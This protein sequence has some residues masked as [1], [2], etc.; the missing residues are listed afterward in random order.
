MQTSLRAL[1]F[2][3]SVWTLIGYGTSQVL[4]LAGNLILTRLLFPEAFGLMVLVN[5]TLQGLNM[6]SDLGLASSIVQ[7]QRGSERI[8]LDTAWTIQV[9][10]GLFLCVVCWIL[11]APLSAFYG[12]PPLSEL[13]PVAG[14]TLALSGF[15]ST[16][17]STLVRD[18]EL[19]KLTA[20]DLTVQAGSLAAMVAWSWWVPTVWALVAGNLIAATLR[21]VLSHTLIPGPRNRP[22]FDR[23]SAVELGHFAR[24]IVLSTL[25]T[26]IAGYSD[27]IVL[28]RVLSMAELGVYN[29]AAVLAL[30]VADA[31]QH[32]ANRVLLPTYARLAEPGS[33]ELSR[34]VTRF[35]VPLLAG[36]L[37]P[38]CVLIAWA[39]EVVSFLYDD[40][41]H[42]AGWML[43]VLAVGTLFSCITVSVSPLLLA[44]GD[45]FRFMLVMAA[46]SAIL[47][48]GMTV[49]FAIAGLTG[50]LVAIALTPLMSYPA[51]AWALR[52]HGAWNPALDFGALLLSAS[53]VGA[54]MAIGT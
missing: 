33:G 43:Q 3:G 4:R 20:L 25:L 35:R 26:F 1:A 23:R 54:L 46:R 29:V 21:L 24:W 30:V 6:L 9:S 38:V 13:L 15:N 40:R 28:G 22:A 18:L 49:G 42:D 8:F 44:V 32:M 45:S 16:S 52:R 19:G 17:L 2:R 12:A 39:P 27:R 10:R 31:M 53:L 51:L 48:S 11:A 14:L 36:A 47:I 5:T 37:V 41:Y 7:N 50:L 34:T